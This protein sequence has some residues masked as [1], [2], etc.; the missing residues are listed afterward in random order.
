MAHFNLDDYETVEERLT[1]FWKDNPNGRIFT[2]LLENSPSRFIVEAHVYRT[3]EDVY[4]WSTGLA[5]ETVQGRGVN[6]TSALENC[7]TSAIG[8]ALA[9]AGYA[10]KGKRPSREEMGKVNAKAAT[11]AAIA[12][13][14]AKMAQ[15][16]KEYVP[17]AKEDDPW[18]IKEAKPVTTVDEAVNIVK[19]II[20]GQTERDIPKC[21]CNRDMAWRTGTGKNGKPWANFS[22]TNVPSRKCQDPIWYEIGA[23][24]AWKPQE[25]KW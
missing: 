8:R 18:T 16:G 3:M 5:E 25:R 10:T 23:D 9:N 21:K 1:K 14:K 20:G 24:G 17:V 6:A 12:E 7:E 4:A 13:A 15:T 19:E 11:E 2:K 22:C